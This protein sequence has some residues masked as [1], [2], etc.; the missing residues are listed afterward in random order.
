MG[1]MRFAT[2]ILVSGFGELVCSM[3]GCETVNSPEGDARQHDEERDSADARNS[4][5]KRPNPRASFR[6]RIQ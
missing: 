2:Y 6:A 1:S 3:N 4:P 5:C